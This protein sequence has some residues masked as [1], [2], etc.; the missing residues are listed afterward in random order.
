MATRL[1]NPVS[2]YLRLGS[3]D[4]SRLFHGDSSDR[5]W[6]WSEEIGQGYIQRIPLRDGLSLMILDHTMHNITVQ[7]IDMLP[8]AIEFSFQ[9]AGSGAGQSMFFPHVGQKTILTR[10]AERRFNVEVFFSTS[11]F[12]PCAHNLIGH[13]L[14]QS[15]EVILGW[16]DWVHSYHLGYSAP[17]SQTAFNKILNGAISSPSMLD[18]DNPFAACHWL[19]FGR[20][21]QPMTP[22]MHQVVHQI[23]SCPY[24]GRTRRTYL[25]R[26]AMTLAALKLAVL[27]QAR[28]LSYPLNNDDVGGV[29]Q[30]AQILLRHI[31]DPPSI[32][33]LAR[34]VGLN[35]LKLNQGFH[36]IYG[37]T[38]FRYLRDC[39]LF[40]AY[41]LLTTSERS[42]EVV[43]NQ[44]GYDSRTSFT[45]AFYQ[46]F[47]LNPKAF[48]MCNRDGLQHYYAS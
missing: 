16:A 47:G 21:W 27:A 1:L 4:D 45:S 14:P 13:L 44:V 11:E 32:K 29:Y 5:I 2:D 6:V 25:E 48:Q 22:E 37:T 30:A 26:K 42:V 36:H 17:S 28:S 31:Q 23:L 19:T 3:A 8:R 24:S 18:A 12:M 35:R 43:A 9:L 15:Q 34:Q 39:R 40:L 10:R 20:L 33:A 38:P 7:E 46:Q 41:Y